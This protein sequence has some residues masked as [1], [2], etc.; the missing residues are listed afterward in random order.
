MVDCDATRTL[1]RS[2]PSLFVNRFL[3]ASTLSFSNQLLRV[4]TP[5]LFLFLF[6][7]LDLC[8][9][10]ANRYR[11][12]GHSPERRLV[13]GKTWCLSISRAFSSVE[14]FASPILSISRRTLSSVAS[15]NAGEAQ[16]VGRCS[17]LRS[18]Y[19]GPQERDFLARICFKSLIWIGR[20]TP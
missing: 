2:P 6:L 13:I 1:P 11:Y 5:F 19:C 12:G 17:E 18:A 9:R 4:H 16:G 14:V 3:I 10:V 20:K 15:D 7:I 8:L